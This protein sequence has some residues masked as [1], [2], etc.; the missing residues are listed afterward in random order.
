M[1]CASY[2]AKGNCN[3]MTAEDCSYYDIQFELANGRA[4][5]MP[6]STFGTIGSKYHIIASALSD[7]CNTNLNRTNVFKIVGILF[8]V[9]SAVG[10]L[11]IGLSCC[12]PK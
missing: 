10:L 8:L 11:L 5:H 6:S 9:I 3:I 7:I 2:D 12:C 4:C 1:V